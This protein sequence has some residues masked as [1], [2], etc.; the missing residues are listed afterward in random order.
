MDEKRKWFLNVE[1]SGED[2]VNIILMITKNL[3]YYINLVDEAMAEFQRINF[4]RC[5]AVDKSLS[6]SNSLQRNLFI[7]FAV[8]G[9]EPLHLP[10]F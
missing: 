3:E 4:K 6:N 10:F 8:L 7:Y 9:F 2:A 1:S 5:Y